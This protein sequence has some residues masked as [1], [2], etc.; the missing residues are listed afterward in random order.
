MIENALNMNIGKYELNIFWKKNILARS[1]ASHGMPPN[2]QQLF[3][4]HFF[5]F[6]FFSM[7]IKN[8]FSIIERF[9]TQN[10]ADIVKLCDF[11]L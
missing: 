1:E 9:F 6:F 2:T 8:A 4:W 11:L 5:Y 7:F 10:V 3:F